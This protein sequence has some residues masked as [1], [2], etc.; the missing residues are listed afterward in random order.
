MAVYKEHMLTCDNFI[1]KTLK[2]K[3]KAKSKKRNVRNG[4][5]N[6]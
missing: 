5:K 2:K 4:R 3:T 1:K 6:R